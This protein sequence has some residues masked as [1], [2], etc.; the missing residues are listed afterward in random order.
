MGKPWM[1]DHNDLIRKADDWCKEPFAIPGGD[2]LLSAFVRLRCLG[3]EA[4]ELVSPA[5]SARYPQR[6]EILM[7]LLN[8]DITRWQEDWLPLFDK[9]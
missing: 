9:G 3:S 8:A 1:I 4:L 6:A 5:H 2:T 7:K